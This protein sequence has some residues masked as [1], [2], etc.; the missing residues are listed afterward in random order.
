MQEWG[1]SE[2][3]TRG[4]EP[5]VEL[6]RCNTEKEKNCS[7]QFCFVVCPPESADNIYTLEEL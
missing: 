1:K 3:P 2:G 5:M 7:L 4:R 6:S